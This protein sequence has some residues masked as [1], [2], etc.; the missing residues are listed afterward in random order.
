MVKHFLARLLIALQI[1]G[2]VFQGAAHAADLADSY[3]IRNE[4]H[5]RSFMSEDGGMRLALGTNRNNNS[6]HDSNDPEILDIIDIPKF[7]QLINPDK[8]LKL[9][10]GLHSITEVDEDNLSEYSNSGLSTD[11][12]D[13]FEFNGITRTSKAAYLTLQGLKIYI[14]NTG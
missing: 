8:E 11:D 3:E 12:E 6:D 14:S 4:I 1:Y 7:E 2:N 5:L 13:R 9:E 10:T